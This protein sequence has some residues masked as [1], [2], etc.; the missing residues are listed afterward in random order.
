[1]KLRYRVAV[2]APLPTGVVAEIERRFGP[3]RITQGPGV[4]VHG[5]VMDQAALRGLLSLLWDLNAEV[6]SVQVAAT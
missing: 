6:I 1:M 2:G 4:T 5:T 3:V